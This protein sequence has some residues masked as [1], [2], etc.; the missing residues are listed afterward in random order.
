MV[1]MLLKFCGPDRSYKVTNEKA[2]GLSYAG[3]YAHKSGTPLRCGSYEI[4]HHK[5]SPRVLFYDIM[6]HSDR[7]DIEDIY[8]LNK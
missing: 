6:L 7:S 2:K 5:E 8:S 1:G 3:A 4:S